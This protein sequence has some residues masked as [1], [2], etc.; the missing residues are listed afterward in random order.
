MDELDRKADQLRHAVLGIMHLYRVVE[1]TI[2]RSP[3]FELSMQE[4][5]V[6]EFLGD[7]GAKM[8]RELA[9]LLLLAV[10]SVT[11]I[12]D[13]LEKKGMV[14]RQ[15]PEEDRRVVLVELTERGKKTFE[16]AAQERKQ[17]YRSMLG[18]LTEEEQEILLVL[19]RKVGR[20]G[21][22]QVERFGETG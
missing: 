5:R 2:A 15:R 10:N 14:R 19:F 12:V 20:T 1:S 9:E 21:R 13:N 7:E 18:S 16:V 4:L 22:S 17:F 3:Q 11:T 8:M 6:V